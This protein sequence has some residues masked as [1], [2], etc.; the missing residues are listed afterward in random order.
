MLS[1]A[2]HLLCRQSIF[3]PLL[4]GYNTAESRKTSNREWTLEISCYLQEFPLLH[5]NNPIWTLSNNKIVISLNSLKINPDRKEGGEKG[6]RE[7]KKRK[8][9]GEHSNEL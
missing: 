4:D 7:G 1:D 3:S 8:E 9:G 6:R 5:A 2:E